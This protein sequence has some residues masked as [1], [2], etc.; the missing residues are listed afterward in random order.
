MNWLQILEAAVVAGIVSS[1]TD[2]Y[3]FG[4]VFH[5]RYHI[6]PGVWRKYRDKKDE[7]RSIAWGTCLVQGVA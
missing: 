3:F 7:M 2:W 5:D 6:Y 4:I 1:F